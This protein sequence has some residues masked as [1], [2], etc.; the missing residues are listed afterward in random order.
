[1]IRKIDL[2]TSECCKKEFVWLE[3]KTNTYGED[4]PKYCPWC[5]HKFTSEIGMKVSMVKQ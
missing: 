4:L 3:P 5:G 2:I 1:M